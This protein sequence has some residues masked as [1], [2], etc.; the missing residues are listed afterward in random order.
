[1]KRIREPIKWS[2][3]TETSVKIQA[4]FSRTSSFELAL[5][6]SQENRW[7]CENNV[8][9]SCSWR[10][11]M[12]YNY[13]C[14]L[15]CSI[16]SGECSLQKFCPRGVGPGLFYWHVAVSGSIRCIWETCWSC[17]RVCALHNNCSLLHFC[18]FN[19]Q[20]VAAV[21]SL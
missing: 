12:L 4:D 8:S 11:P 16:L 20:N 5:S 13:T 21:W 15:V 7:E 18:L 2:P 1:M 19:L 14:F 17:S 9:V 6:T 3:R 10:Y